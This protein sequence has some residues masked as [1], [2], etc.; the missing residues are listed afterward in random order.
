M[1][2]HNSQPGQIDRHHLSVYRPSRLAV[3]HPTF[4]IPYYSNTVA[5][6]I[7][8]SFVFANDTGWPAGVN[9][10]AAHSI[11]RST[12]APPPPPP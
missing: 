4:R 12:E 11:S 8:L 2:A 10:I 5:Y 7:P 6:T 1:G 3:R 9:Q